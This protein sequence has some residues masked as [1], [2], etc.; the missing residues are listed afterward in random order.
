LEECYKISDVERAGEHITK[1]EVKW[2]ESKKGFRLPTEYEWELFAKAGTNNRWAGTDDENDLSLYA[3]HRYGRDRYSD[4]ISHEVGSLRPNKWDLYD[5]SGN[6][7]EWCW[8]LVDPE[9]N[10]LKHVVRGGSYE[11]FADHCR[12]DHRSYLWLSDY[13]KYC[14]FRL[15]RTFI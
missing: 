15:C 13:A 14:G 12:I 11:G 2:D 6:V 4:R 5:M 10:T 3:W 1:A 8:D 7:E 9:N